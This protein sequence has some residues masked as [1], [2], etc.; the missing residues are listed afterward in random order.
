MSAPP[1]DGPFKC[2]APSLPAPNQYTNRGLSICCRNE[3]PNLSNSKLRKRVRSSPLSAPFGEGHF[4]RTID[5][6]ALIVV[7]ASNQD[8]KLPISVNNL[9]TYRLKIPGAPPRGTCAPNIRFVCRFS[10]ARPRYR[11]RGRSARTART[12]IV[13]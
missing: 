1:V 13:A 4:R 6:L 7:H 12:V 8:I 3:W 2:H 5:P 10:I 9:L 11:P